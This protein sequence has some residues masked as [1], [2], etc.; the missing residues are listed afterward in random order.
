VHGADV[1]SDVD[2][3]LKLE[4]DHVLPVT[5]AVLDALDHQ[6]N[7]EP[8]ELQSSTP[9]W[10][11]SEHGAHVLFDA[12]LELKLEAVS[13]LPVTNAVHHVTEL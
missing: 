8:A 12:D 7:R 5:N 13:V 6:L 3:E 1:R 11:L 2:E 4:P 10:E 9:D